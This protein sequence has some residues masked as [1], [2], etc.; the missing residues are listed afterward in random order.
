METHAHKKLNTTVK[1]K[2][3]KLFWLNGQ[4]KMRPSLKLKSLAEPRNLK[5][6]RKISAKLKCHENS[7]LKVTDLDG[8]IKKLT[9]LDGG[10]SKR[11]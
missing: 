10:N 1:L 5:I 7:C 6:V 4:I 3:R 9:A 11:V 2:P 8:A